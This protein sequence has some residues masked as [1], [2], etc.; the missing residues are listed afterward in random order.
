MTVKKDQS[1]YALKQ[2][3]LTKIDPSERQAALSEAQNE[4]KLLKRGIPKVLKSYGSHYDQSKLLF[5]FST[6][7]MEMNL[8]N[9]IEKNG[10]L[11]L[12]NFIPIFSD[13]ITGKYLFLF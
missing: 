12:E 8:S 2:I 3:N 5:K 11:N 7:L 1:V 13:I 4:Y 6:D 9:Y 10:A